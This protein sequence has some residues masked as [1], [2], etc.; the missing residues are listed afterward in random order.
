MNNIYPAK[1]LLF[2]EYSLM[3]GSHAL[4]V[5]FWNFSGRWSQNHK[6][7]GFTLALLKFAAYLEEN[8]STAPFVVNIQGFKNDLKDG[9]YFESSIPMGY[10]VGS[11][12]ALCAAFYE[13]YV[14][15]RILPDCADDQ[16]ARLK[17]HFSFIESFFHGSSSGID[18][19]ISYTKS[20]IYFGE[21]DFLKRISLDDNHMEHVS[22]F[23]I[24]SKK[25]G[26][27]SRNIQLFK[28]LLK[29]A[30][31]LQELKGN[32][33]PLV[34]KCISMFLEDKPID[35]LSLVTRLSGKQQSLFEPMMPVEF[36]KYFQLARESGRFSLKLCG[37]GSGGF[38]LGFTSDME[39]VDS[40]L[41]NSGVKPV[42]VRFGEVLSSDL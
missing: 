14:E 36:L 42:P 8:Q 39:H 23:L 35:F 18:P 37:S 28:D 30:Y 19:L 2:G 41:D 15:D 11:S 34:N 17:T 4:A 27:T 25:Q 3:Y 1:I 5:P 32:Y 10:G 13:R 29:E 21:D 24:D 40:L 9:V 16:L 26:N 31:Y 22:V 7:A 38:M 33:I 12:G 20:A 6:N